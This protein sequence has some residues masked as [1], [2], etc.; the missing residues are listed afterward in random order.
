[1]ATDPRERIAN[2]RSSIRQQSNEFNFHIRR[3]AFAINDFDEEL[4]H[5]FGLPTGDGYSSAVLIRFDRELR[6]FIRALVRLKLQLYRYK[7]ATRPLEHQLMVLTR[8]P[9]LDRQTPLR[10]RLPDNQES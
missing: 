2:L 3:I 10:E 7:E 6:E 9:T 4:D 1:M 5:V 8:A